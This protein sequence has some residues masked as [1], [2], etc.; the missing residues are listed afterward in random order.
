MKW[1]GKIL[2]FSLLV[3]CQWLGDPFIP[4]CH[5]KV[6]PHHISTFHQRPRRHSSIN[7]DLHLDTLLALRI[8]LRLGFG[9]KYFLSPTHQKPDAGFSRAC[10][11]YDWLEG[12]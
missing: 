9:H 6:L 4:Y 10:S 8:V 2:V 3:R 7:D 12:R 11:M 1:L 5:D